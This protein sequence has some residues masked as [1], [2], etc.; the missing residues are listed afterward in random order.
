M[1]S[2]A[3]G[4]ILNKFKALMTKSALKVALRDMDYQHHGG[5]PLLGVNGISIIGHGSSTPL[6]IKNMVL[7]AKEMHELNI[8]QKFE[9]SIK[10]YAIK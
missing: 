1:R 10:E 9:E 7:R 2:Y 4:G 5:I 6:A 8:L 3:D